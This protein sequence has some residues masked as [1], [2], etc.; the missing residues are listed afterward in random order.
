MIRQL[1]FSFSQRP[2]WQRALLVA[3]TIIITATLFWIGIIVVFSLAI[4]ALAVA[5]VNRIKMKITGRPLFKG[6]KHFHRYQS[7]FQKKDV[8]E[9][10]VVEHGKD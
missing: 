1:Q 9:G 5:F 3:A 4:V 10:E 2:A 7:Q 8:I 6:P